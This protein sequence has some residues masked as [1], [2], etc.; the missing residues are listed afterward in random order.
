MRKTLTYLSIAYL[1]LL[2]LSCS[3]E[4]IISPVNESLVEMPIAIDIVAKSQ[5]QI[6]TRVITDEEMAGTCNVDKIKLLVY[7]A[8]TQTDDRRTLTFHSEQELECKKEGG[9][10]V[11][12]GSITGTAGNYYSIFALGYSSA[13]ASSFEI[14]PNTLQAGATT[15]GDTKVSLKYTTL[16]GTLNSY[17]TPEFFAGSV[18]PKGEVNEIFQA[19]DEVK[20]TGTLYRAVGKVQFSLTNIPANIKK[21]SLLSEKIAE[22]NIFYRL[23]ESGT[24]M[25]QYPMGIPEE[26]ELR[27]YISEIVSV[28][29]PAET[30]WQASLESYLIPLKE[31]LLYVDATDNDNKTTRYLIKCA[32]KMH[33]SIWIY[34]LGYG[35]K[36]YRFSIPPN[37]QIRISGR[38]EQLQNSGNVLIDL[39]DIGEFEGGFLPEG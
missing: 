38:F 19:N 30:E 14:L 39:S 25:S 24:I 5:S 4:E 37:Y 1:S 3:S 28:E 31:S 29:R 32:D 17:N 10:W 12:R 7:S 34:V 26:Y 18:I 13:E 20:L 22:Y 2:L 23:S 15:Y 35:V 9:K 36:S 21:V 8:T 33:N 16:T 11:A 27:K 6:E